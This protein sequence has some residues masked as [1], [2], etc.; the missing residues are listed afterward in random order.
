MIVARAQTPVNWRRARFVIIVAVGAGV[1]IAILAILGAFGS[2]DTP[3]VQW[4][5]GAWDCCQVL[6]GGPFGHGSAPQPV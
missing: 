5:G 3:S 6:W 4:G 2:H 1:L